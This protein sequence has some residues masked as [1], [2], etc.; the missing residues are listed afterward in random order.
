MLLL[1]LFSHSRIV[2]AS[3]A[4]SGVSFAFVLPIICACPALRLSSRTRS[5]DFGERGEG[6]AFSMG[7]R[8]LHA[9]LVSVGLFF[10]RAA[11]CLPL[12]RRGGQAGSTPLCLRLLKACRPG[13]R[14]WT[15]R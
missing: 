1:L 8:V 14:K 7:C 12:A 10:W 9:R 5:P 11:A 3:A 13:V 6:S 2:R 15:Y 4:R